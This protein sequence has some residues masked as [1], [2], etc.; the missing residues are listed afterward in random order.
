MVDAALVI[1]EAQPFP[2]V[3]KNRTITGR[4]LAFDEILAVESVHRAG[5][6]TDT[7]FGVDCNTFWRG[8]GLPGAQVPRQ[9]SRIESKQSARGALRALFNVYGEGSRIDQRESPGL[10]MGFGG[11]FVDESQERV[12]EMG[13]V[14]RRTSKAMEMN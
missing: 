12:V 1:V 9:L 5:H 14:A 10:A 3:E 13:R 8:Q 4:E 11:V 6:A 2:T 7:V